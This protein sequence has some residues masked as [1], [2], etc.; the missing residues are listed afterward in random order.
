MYIKKSFERVGDVLERILNVII[1]AAMCGMGIILGANIVMR[2]LFHH[3]IHWSN[4]IS[5]YLYIYIVLLG[6]AVSYKIGTH[7]KIEFVRNS[8]SKNL[9]VFL[10]LMHYI[11]ML[12]ISFLLLIYGI[13]HVITMWP[14]HAPVLTF[15]PVGI[16]YLSVPICAIMIIIVTINFTLKVRIR[17]E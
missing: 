13:L 6:T 7:A 9:K 14:V 8:A 4:E 12:F 16:V 3:P 1:F 17:G 2:F 10:D 5:R 15:L 11:V